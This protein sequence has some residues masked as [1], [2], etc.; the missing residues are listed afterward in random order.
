LGK[1]KPLARQKRREPIPA[2]DRL[3]Q[4]LRKRQVL[5]LKFR[6]QHAIARFIIDF[7]CAEARLIVEVDGPIHAYT[8]E[9]DDVRQ[10]FLESLGLRVLCF[11]NQ[12]ILDSPDTVVEQNRGSP[13]ARE[14][15]ARK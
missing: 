1:L 4:R 7:Y 8:P 14:S 11:T 5:G 12:E 9:A 15:R 6:R 3:W 10:E 2:E 13:T